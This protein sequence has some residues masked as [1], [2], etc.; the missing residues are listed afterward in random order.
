MKKF[1]ARKMSPY[2]L[3]AGDVTCRVNDWSI[4]STCVLLRVVLKNLLV[5]QAILSVA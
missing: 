3:R 1:R 5:L 2:I 4:A